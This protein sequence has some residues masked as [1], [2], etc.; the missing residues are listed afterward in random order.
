MA[1]RRALDSP[2]V[3]LSHSGIPRIQRNRSRSTDAYTLTSPAGSADRT[4][5][6]GAGTIVRAPAQPYVRDR[7]AEQPR[8][9]TAVAAGTTRRQNPS[10]A[11]I[12]AVLALGIPLPDP[13]PIVALRTAVLASLVCAVPDTQSAAD[14]ETSITATRR[15]RPAGRGVGTVPVAG[16]RN[17]GRDRSQADVHQDLLSRGKH[18]LRALCDTEGLQYL[19]SHAAQVDEVVTLVVGAP[20]FC[21]VL[22]CTAP[23]PWSRWATTPGTPHH[24]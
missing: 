19:Y 20:F 8:R 14:D 13:P 2:T 1:P 4:L 18:S 21:A 24:P 16:A 15:G 7:A 12:G 11:Q 22:F 6:P 17:A 9:L 10:G 23:C 3:A 5:S